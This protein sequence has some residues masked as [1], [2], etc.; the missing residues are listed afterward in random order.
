MYTFVWGILISAF[1]VDILRSKI[2]LSTKMTEKINLPE[3]EPGPASTG[4]KI[5]IEGEKE[6][7]V[8]YDSKLKENVII[9][10][11][12]CTS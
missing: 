5:K 10:I 12:Y 2:D 3:E 7:E 9:K 11:M 6:L 1:I 8:K 4:M